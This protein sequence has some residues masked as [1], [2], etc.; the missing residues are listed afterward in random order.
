MT[1]KARGGADR[2]FNVIRQTETKRD[3][4]KPERIGGNTET[5]RKKI[6]KKVQKIRVGLPKYKMKKTIEFEF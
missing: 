4:M 6:E 3:I 2:C 5:T 1:S